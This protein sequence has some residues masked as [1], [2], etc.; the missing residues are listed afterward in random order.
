[1]FVCWVAV[2]AYELTVPLLFLSLGVRTVGL[3]VGATE[4]MGDLVDCFRRR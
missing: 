1:M 3:R 2:V 4:E